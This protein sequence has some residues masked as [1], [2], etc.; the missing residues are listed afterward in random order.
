MRVNH[1]DAQTGLGQLLSRL[2][3]A[4]DQR[5]EGDY[6]NVIIRAFD[7]GLAKGDQV[8]F[9]RDSALGGV[10][11]N[12]FDKDHR[13]RFAN[14]SFDQAFGVVASGGH[15]PLQARRVHKRGFQA[16]RMLGSKAYLGGHGHADHERGLYLSAPVVANFSG[17]IDNRVHGKGG[18]V[19]G[20]EFG[21]V[22]PAG[23]GQTDAKADDGRF[24]QGAIPH[25]RPQKPSYKP[26]V[27]PKTPPY[28]TTSPPRTTI[29]GSRRISS[30]IPSL[31]A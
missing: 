21:D 24:I 10:A 5:R 3:N 6:G 1:F 14:G 20:L 11:A 18:K 27:T 29:L 7:F 12:I 23:N 13:V 19:H 30:R 25:P 26:R 8:F 17:L 4:G 9:I 15:G 16:L 28:L 31:I 22:G 2:Q